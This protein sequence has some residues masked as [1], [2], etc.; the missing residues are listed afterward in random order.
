MVEGG[1]IQRNADP[2]T[3][4]TI[5]HPMQQVPVLH[6]QCIDPGEDVPLPGLGVEALNLQ[7]LP[8]LRCQHHLAHLHLPT[9]HQLLITCPP[10][11]QKGPPHCQI[12]D[13]GFTINPCHKPPSVENQI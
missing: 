3:T 1:M 9:L 13:E 2:Q 4:D 7:D 11:N 12:K 8:L 10:F 6:I 5:T